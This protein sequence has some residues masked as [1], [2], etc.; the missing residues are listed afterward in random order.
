MNRE[1]RSAVDQF[2][3]RMKRLAIYDPLYRLERKKGKDASGKD[4]PYYELG[5]LTLLFFFEN[6]IMRQKNSGL[7]ELSR[8]LEEICYPKIN[9]DE[10]GFYSVAKEILEVYRP[11]N[12][13]RNQKT[14]YNWETGQEE[15][16]YYSILKMVGKTP[17]FEFSS[18]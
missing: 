3:E 17:M 5:M 10:E 6:M 2:G 11:S 15:T 9:L 12:G 16:V 18:L 7:N 1:A 13:K 8:F 4:I 14:F